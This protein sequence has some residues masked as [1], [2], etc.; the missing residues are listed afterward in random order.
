MILPPELFDVWLAEG[1]LVADAAG[2]LRPAPE[3]AVV[4]DQA[5]TKVNAVRNEGPD[6]LAL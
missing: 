3:N 5:S 6:L 1:P 4:V 2:I